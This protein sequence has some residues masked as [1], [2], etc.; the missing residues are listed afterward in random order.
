[1]ILHKLAEWI[2]SH[3]FKPL[4]IQRSAIE[5]QVL[6]HFSGNSCMITYPPNLAGLVSS[7][8]FSLVGS[9]GE[10]LHPRFPVVA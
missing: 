1:M 8:F 10:Y 6:K 4:R 9:V 2:K 7:F 3:E 5:L